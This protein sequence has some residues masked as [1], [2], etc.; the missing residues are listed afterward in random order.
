MQTEI[1]VTEV[2]AAEEGFGSEKSGG[3]GGSVL[4]ETEVLDGR[5]EEAAPGTQ[6]VAL[7]WLK[8]DDES[9]GRFM[10]PITRG[11]LLVVDDG[12]NFAPRA[13]KV[14]DPVGVELE[15]LGLDGLRTLAIAESP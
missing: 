9:A 5:S 14:E 11:S 12:G 3:V 10:R 2:I 15:A 4:V 1:R 8:R 6:V 7:L 13:A